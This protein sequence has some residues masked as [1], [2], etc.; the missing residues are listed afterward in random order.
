MSTRIDI[1]C[2]QPVVFTRAEHSH[3][4]KDPFRYQCQIGN[5][6]DR[7]GVVNPGHRYAGHGKTPSEALDAAL[8]PALERLHEHELKRREKDDE[9]RKALDLKLVRASKGYTATVGNNAFDVTRCRAKGRRAW[10]IEVDG[11]DLEI[12]PTLHE[13]RLAIARFSKE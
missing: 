11:F 7:G 1:G 5:F 13:V 6:V 9:I 8:M 2:N 10:Q 12:V 4:P 3:G